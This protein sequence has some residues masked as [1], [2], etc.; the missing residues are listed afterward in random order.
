MTVAELNRLVRQTIE[1]TIP[2][3]WIRGE[4]SNFT[5]AGSGH[6]YFSLKDDKAQVRCAMFRN[7]N[8]FLQ[9][10]PAD[11][12]AVEAYGVVTLYEPRGDYQLVVEQLRLAG[13]GALFEAFE[14]LKRKLE[15][16]GLFAPER[17]RALPAYPRQIGVVTSTTG[18]ALRDVLKVLRSRS[19]H[20]PV[21]I[22]PTLV[23]GTAAADGIVAALD[24]A[25]DRNECD[26]LLLCRGGGSLEDLWPFNE[27]KVARAIARSPIPIVSG[28]GHETDFTIA[29]FVAD[30]RAPTPTAAASACA[31]DRAQLL[32]ALRDNSSWLK[33]SWSRS[34]EIR[35]QRLDL[36]AGRLTHPRDRLARRR[37]ILARLQSEFHAVRLRRLSA[38]RLAVDR[39]ALQLARLRPN[40]A[41]H[42][43]QLTA[44]RNALQRAMATR[45]SR[46][47]DSLAASGQ[48][49][50]HLNPDN[51]LRRGFSMVQREDGTIVSSASQIAVG[52]GV[53]LRFGSGQAS[54]RITEKSDR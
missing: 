47:R 28:V 52:E 9:S 53:H 39:C 35:M 50:G 45:L 27:E 4:I 14:K 40:V 29:D 23:Q 37:E 8:Q 19:P 5:R 49:L 10:P 25:Y 3:L 41:F 24:A 7:R 22:Y 11:G 26:V 51:V 1:Q 43:A 44:Q 20:I 38:I 33:R 54:A 6:W 21:V 13:L 46:L 32:A 16:E 17:K 31:P 48:S 12:L 2:P 30:T 34:Q 15:A 18:A 36:L 42:G